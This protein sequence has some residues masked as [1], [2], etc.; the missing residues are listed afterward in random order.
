MTLP[1]R[2]SPFVGHA[3]RLSLCVAPIG[4]GA[5]AQQ[6]SPA[7]A[8]ATVKEVLDAHIAA[9]DMPSAVVAYGRKGEPTRLV[10]MGRTTQ[11]PDSPPV[12]GDTIFRINSITK[13]IV[14]LTG[15]LAIED[16]K[17][18]LDQ[19]VSDFF[20]AFKNMRV[21]TSLET[22]LDSRPTSTQIT[23][24]HLL[25][26][27]SGLGLYTNSKGPLLKAIHD[28][29]LI[30][31][32]TNRASEAT[33]RLTRPASA[34]AFAEKVAMLPLEAEPGARWKY[35]IGLD[36]LVAVIERAVGMPY[37]DYLNA[38]LLKPLKMNSSGFQV[39]AKDAARLTN[40]WERKDGAL[41]IEDDAAD[42]VFLDRPSFP[43][44]GSGMV[45]TANDLDRLMQMIQNGGTFDGV[46]VMKPESVALA[47]SDLLPP[48]ATY[49][50]GAEKPLGPTEP[51]SGF[52]AGGS[53]VLKGDADY[54]RST[55]G[56]AGG[57][58][59]RLSVDP[60]G[61]RIVLL[62]NFRPSVKTTLRRDVLHAAAVETRAR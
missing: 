27:T 47:T 20:P 18:A 2:L 14:G 4:G 29:G 54:G 10:A 9:G 40:A 33:R 37:E 26:H 50:P 48:G 39:A 43:Y 46:R 36:I 49:P 42:S 32:Q 8:A 1:K 7:P 41:I 57:M 24:R 3:L 34:Q 51:R 22:S 62:L 17:L 45:S 53:V 31:G 6:A 11:R 16:G 58:G 12:D 30:P 56:W 44:G 15:I 38:R 5:L 19:P 25:T 52:G 23:V 55:F 60:N 61:T 13:V 59:P 21:V 35:T 28:A